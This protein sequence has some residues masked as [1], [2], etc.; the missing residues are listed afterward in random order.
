M[1]WL[2]SYF[3]SALSD[4]SLS[5]IWIRELRWLDSSI[6]ALTSSL[7][8]SLLLSY[9]LATFLSVISTW[10]FENVYISYRWGT[11]HPYPFP[12]PSPSALKR[13][14]SR[15]S[16]PWG[17]S[18]T[19]ALCFLSRSYE[20]HN[21]PKLQVTFIALYNQARS[22][23]KWKCNRKNTKRMNLYV[24]RLKIGHQ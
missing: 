21:C 9:E 24:K 10:L 16:A 4:T 20:Q 3:C 23:F 17:L 5:V 11:E 6:N 7:I 18:P 19:S 14:S 22:L 12:R 15:F 1:A 2:N 8:F 13:L